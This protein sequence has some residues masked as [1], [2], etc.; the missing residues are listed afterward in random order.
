MKAVK[1]FAALLAAG[2][3]L[4]GCG[5][6]EKS[7][8][9]TGRSSSFDASSENV[10]EPLS[11]AITEPL[12]ESVSETSSG[13]GN[14]EV[15]EIS[16]TEIS[17][18][19]ESE[20]EPET[21]C[22]NEE[23]H[24]SFNPHVFGSR[25]LEQFGEEKRD[26]FFAFVDALR[27]GEDSFP[28]PDADTAG[29]CAGR[30]QNF[31]FPV[32]GSFIEAGVWRDGTAQIV[33]L[34]PKEEFLQKEQEFEAAI[35][36][37]LNDC[38]SDDY[39]DLEKTLALYEYMTM[40]HVYDREMA[41]FSLEW[42]D[43]QSPYRC[44]QEKRGICN[45]IAGLYNYL[46]LQAGID[47]EEMGGAVHYST[48]LTEGHSWVYVTMNGKSYHID[49]T[50]GLTESR[51]PLCYFMMTDEIREERDCFPRDTYTLAAWGDQ[52][53]LHCEFEAA[54]DTFAPMWDSVYLGMNRAN[55]EIV[56]RDYNGLVHRF[57][58]AGFPS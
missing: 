28:C 39:N 26:A 43:R 23:G 16:F 10:S 21:I 49:P 19:P 1:I 11:E 22:S 48:G 56:Y 32:A 15:S 54:D 20:P 47:S 46:L 5:T 6:A 37:I 29:W 9:E 8:Q 44:L 12:S 36:G 50:Y 57:S 7:G 4:A 42:M 30:L 38:L 55:Q 52:T 3:L 40:N 34:I 45:E 2:I 13:A 25:Y 41:G 51:P 58:Y 31:F 53:R 27:N 35:T 18:I 14:T 17:E 24:Y 33:Y